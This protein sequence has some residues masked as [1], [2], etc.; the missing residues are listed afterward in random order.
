M[1][2]KRIFEAAERLQTESET[3]LDAIREALPRLEDAVLGNDL[4]ASPE[5]AAL[6]HLDF[7]TRSTRRLLIA[8]DDLA[9]ALGGK[10]SLPS[11]RNAQVR[12]GRPP[13]PVANQKPADRL[14]PFPQVRRT[15][16]RGADRR[17]L[18]E[19]ARRPRH[20]HLAAPGH[21]RH[22]RS[23]LRSR[24]LPPGNRGGPSS[25]RS[26]RQPAPKTAQS[27]RLGAARRPL[28]KQANR[29]AGPGI[30]NGNVG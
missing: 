14:L 17:N 22:R 4:Q 8:L 18:G 3:L 28:R 27:P 23:R 19:T 2:D 1:S 20:P 10:P 5:H 25:R 21:A 13:I 6:T 29:G 11:I 24:R 15:L 30:C 7:V 16:R 9:H 12:L 26:P